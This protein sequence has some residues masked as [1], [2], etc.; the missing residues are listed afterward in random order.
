M[1][2][3]VEVPDWLDVSD[4]TRDSL[5]RF[6]V[7][8][9]QWTAKINLISAST[10]PDLWQRHIL[11]SAQL[12]DL[13]SQE[14]VWA[15]L[16]SGGGFPAVV[17]AIMARDTRPDAV[18]NLI[19]SDQRKCA[20]LRKVVG[21]LGLKAKVHA[22]RAESLPAVGAH[23]LTARALAPLTDLLAHVQ[24]HL[25]P[26]GRAILPKGTRAMEEVDLA[27]RK[28]TFDLEVRPSRTDAN[29]QILLIENLRNV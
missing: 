9:A 21:D 17:L 25:H 11:D 13:A 5:L 23:T 22:V 19:E 18:F 12:F 4:E 24:H 27:R 2:E 29:A 14:P 20:F 7:M 26:Q 16:G 1:V 10:V 6:G 8:V 15:D 28:W 3:Q